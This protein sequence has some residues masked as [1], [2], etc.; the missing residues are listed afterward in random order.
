MWP[1]ASR[2]LVK[3][4]VAARESSLADSLFH[5]KRLT[6]LSECSFSGVHC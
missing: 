3:S 5:D 6:L 4:G 2:G 1:K